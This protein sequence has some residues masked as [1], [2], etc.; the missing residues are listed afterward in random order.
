M[1]AHGTKKG[2]TERQRQGKAR[3]WGRR[4]KELGG[5]KGMTEKGWRQSENRGRGSQNTKA[6]VETER[7][8]DGWRG[9]EER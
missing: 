5:G 3:G 6:V 4:Q 7:D 2:G 8:I 1:G 9:T